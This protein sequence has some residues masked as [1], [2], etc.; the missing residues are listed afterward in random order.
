MQ[1]PNGE[2]VPPLKCATCPISSGCSW[3]CLRGDDLAEI[4]E[5]RDDMLRLHNEKCDFFEETIRLKLALQSIVDNKDNKN[6]RKPE[7]VHAAQ[8]A[9]KGM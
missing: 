2:I 1:K 4:A 5:M 9:L 7:C 8:A 6:W 3:D